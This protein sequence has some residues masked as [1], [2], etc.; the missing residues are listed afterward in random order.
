MSPYSSAHSRYRR[1]LNSGESKHG[2]LIQAINIKE[3]ISD[4]YVDDRQVSRLFC[5]I[6]KEG[7]QIPAE[8]GV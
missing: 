1:L 3:I 2:L 7:K 4:V 6:F 5:S 8:D